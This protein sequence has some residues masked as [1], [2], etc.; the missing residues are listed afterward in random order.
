VFYV[1]ARNI[2]GKGLKLFIEGPVPTGFW[3]PFGSPPFEQVAHLATF[4]GI[5]IKPPRGNS[6][7]E[8][9]DV[10]VKIQYSKVIIELSK[11]FGTQYKPHE[12]ASQLLTM[13]IR[14]PDKKKFITVVYP[15]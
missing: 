11:I 10:T 2:S 15:K 6:H 3:S 8:L 4:K 13:I 14:S 1:E 12:E 9:G 5:P 7:V